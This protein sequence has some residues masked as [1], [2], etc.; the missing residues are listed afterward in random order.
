MAKVNDAPSEVVAEAGEVHVDGPAGVVVAFTPT[1]AAET[2]DRLLHA[3][4]TA[5][6]QQLEEE[7]V[8]AERESQNDAGS[9]AQ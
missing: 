9:Q 5:R 8:Q 3:A 7:R 4:A 2:S 1:A 6:G